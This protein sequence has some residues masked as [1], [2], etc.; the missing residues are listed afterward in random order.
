MLLLDSGS[1]TKACFV[2][3]PFIRVATATPRG[4]RSL[5]M[6]GMAA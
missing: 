4:F 1:R 3:S 2:K 6:I 5:T